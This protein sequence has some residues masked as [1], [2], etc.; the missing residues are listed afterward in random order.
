M[1][2]SRRR[3]DRGGLDAWPGYVDALSTLLMVII[4]VLLVFVLA[5]GFLGAALS[6]RDQAL[7]QLNRQVAELSELLNLERVQVTELRSTLGRTVQEL[8]EAAAARDRLA[9]DLRAAEQARAQLTSE[10]DAT[11]AENE[12]ATARIADLELAARGAAQ[13]LAGIETRLTEANTRAER[14]GEEAAQTMARLTEATRALETERTARTAAEARA[15]EVARNLAEA[16]RQLEAMRAE[17]AELNRTVRADRETIEMRLADL[18]RLSEQ[19]RALTAL[20]DRMEAELRQQGAARQTAE[21]ATQEATRLGDSARAQVALLSRQI[22]ELRSQLSRITAALDLAEAQGRDKDV[23]IANLGQR[24]NAALAA[25]VETLQRYRSDFFGKLREVLGNRPEIRVVGDRFVFQ[26]EVL[27]PPGSAE[28]SEAGQAQ[29]RRV[30]GVLRDIARRIPADV[31]WVLRVDGHAD[32]TPISNQ[33]FAS[34][35]ELSAA[36]AIAVSRLLVQEGLP[37]NRVAAAAFGENQPL[38]PGETAEA[39]ARNRRIEFRLTDR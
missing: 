13:R 37:A 24:L 14:A 34:N 1:A 5:Q 25:Q 21:A 20:R 3:G 29:I 10:R 19:I 33:R 32:R 31:N 4:F 22:D 16:Q 35:W 8:R 36:R 2:L 7:E 9:L 38:D 18:A 11:R 27:F 39:F 30:G 6:S 23:Q 28:L 17:L 15:A 26:S 12:R